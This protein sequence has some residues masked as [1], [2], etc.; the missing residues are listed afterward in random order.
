MGHVCEGSQQWQSI[1]I[2]TF[3][4]ACLINQHALGSFKSDP[5]TFTEFK[6]V[7]D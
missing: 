2:L 4:L 7:D 6:E 3:A 5:G 1:T